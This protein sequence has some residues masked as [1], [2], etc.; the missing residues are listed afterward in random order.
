MPSRLPL[1]G[2]VVAL[3]LGAGV[4]AS[5]VPAAAQVPVAG[6]PATPRALPSGWT[7]VVWRGEPLLLSAALSPARVRFAP[8]VTSPARGVPLDYLS[9]WTWDPQTGVIRSWRYGAP[10]FVNTLQRFETGQRYWLHATADL[11]WGE[12]SPSIL[13][14]AQVVSLYGYPGIPGMGVLGAYSADGAASEAIRRAAEYAA[15]AGGEV[16]PALHLIVAVGQAQPGSDG[17]YLG[18]MPSELLD[19]Y[20]R[21]TRERGLLLFLDVQIGWSDPLAETKRLAPWLAESHVHLA[22]DPEFATKRKGEPPGVAIG[23]V[24][25]AEVNQVQA[26]LAGL[27]AGRKIL[28]V[29]QFRDDMVTAPGDIRA[30]D[31]VDLVIDMDGF[32]PRFQKLWG[33]DRYALSAYSQYPAIKLFLAWDTPLM[34]PSEIQGLATPPRIVIYQ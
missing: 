22:L 13:D 32:G 1:A 11:A 10:A 3:A 4:F 15:L 21:V 2:L 31:G 26:Y 28:V 9:V 14:R 5:S 8:D 24:T 34:P 29:H 25:G 19:E 7:A 6:V 18:R 16:L 30:T 23:T 33:Y 27:G 17:L 12:A 20:V